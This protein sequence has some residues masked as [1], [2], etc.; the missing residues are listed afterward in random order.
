VEL[1]G[2]TVTVESA[3]PGHGSTFAI[4]LPAR[5]AAAARTPV[6]R[7]A[8]AETPTLAG[9]SVLVVDDDAD[10]REIIVRAVA[11]AGASVTAVASSA[12]ALAALREESSRFDVVVSDIGMPGEDGYFLLRELRTMPFDGTGQI[13]I[14]AVTAYATSEDRRRALRAGFVAHI[15]K[16]FV[17]LTLIST[18][19][20]A[21]AEPP[22]ALDEN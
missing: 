7:P 5:A 20:R 11:D 22:L 2:G 13:P 19:A 15:A 14:I 18:I 9:V 3:G 6:R 10:G 17:P 16:P 12:E 21:A 1:H 4:Q 8:A